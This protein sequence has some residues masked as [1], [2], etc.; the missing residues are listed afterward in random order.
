[1]NTTKWEDEVKGKKMKWEKRLWQFL[2]TTPV[3]VAVFDGFFETKKILFI[4]NDEFKRMKW[5]RYRRMKAVLLR[6][7]F[8]WQTTVEHRRTHTRVRPC[9]FIYMLCKAC[10]YYWQR[11]CRPIRI[12][13]EVVFI[14][15]VSKK[16]VIVVFCCATNSSECSYPYCISKGWW[17]SVP[18]SFYFT[19]LKLF[20]LGHHHFDEWDP[21]CRY[22][23]IDCCFRTVFETTVFVRKTLK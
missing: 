7:Y 21:F 6:L 15:S 18:I 23:A 12:D 2:A 16:A 9:T 19:S 13:K 1:M 4:A 5:W 14:S 20:S 22:F 8:M 3:D 10:I 11:R 17:F